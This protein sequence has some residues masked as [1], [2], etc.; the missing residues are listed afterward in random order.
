MLKSCLPPVAPGTLS[1]LHRAPGP[2]Q[3]W[4]ET[5]SLVSHC[6]GEQ[7][8]AFSLPALFSRGTEDPGVAGLQGLTWGGEGSG[9]DAPDWTWEVETR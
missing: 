4:T 8:Q 3:I 2:P 9:G 5:P 6:C 1:V 7:L